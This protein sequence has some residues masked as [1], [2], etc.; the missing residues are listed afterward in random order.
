M[1][2]STHVNLYLIC[3]N[4]IKVTWLSWKISKQQGIQEQTT[5]N[6]TTALV[7]FS[8]FPYIFSKFFL[9]DL[10]KG[11]TCF[12]IRDKPSCIDL[13]LTNRPQN[14]KNVTKKADISDFYKF[15]FNN[16]KKEEPKI[17]QDEVFCVIKFFHII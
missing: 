9:S 7:F 16:F 14:F 17:F 12:K 4:T 2:F 11:P 1:Q 5:W 8:N 10:V 13:F 6:G 15:V 3:L